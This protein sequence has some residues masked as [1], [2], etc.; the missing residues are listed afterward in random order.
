MTIVTPPV[1]WRVQYFRS[2]DR[3][4]P[5]VADVVHC[6]D[7]GLVKIIAHSATGGTSR[8]IRD[9]VRHADDPHFREFPSS[10]QKSGCWDYI[11]GLVYKP[12]K[13]EIIKEEEYVHR[14]STAKKRATEARKQREQSVPA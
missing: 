13:E 9:Y 2:D 14:M 5:F 11:R 8:L 7:H 12:T 3:S 4:Q 10:L 1:G 6:G